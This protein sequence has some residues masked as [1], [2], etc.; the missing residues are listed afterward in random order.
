MHMDPRMI[1]SLLSAVRTVACVIAASLAAQVGAQ[2][3]KGESINVGA[4]IALTGGG[5]GVG[6]PERNGILLGQKVVNQRGGIN[7]R[8]LNVIIEDDGTSPDAA[9]TKV[10]QLV[11]SKKVAGILGTT[12]LGNTVAVGA[13]TAPL[14]LP[15]LAFSGIGPAV[16]NSRTCVFHMLPPQDLNARALLEYVTK[17]LKVKRVGVLHDS[18]YGNVVMASLKKVAAEYAV[19]FVQVEKFEIAAT[20]VTTQAA[21]V[22]AASP[23][24]VLV[25]ASTATAFRNAKQIKIEVPIVAAIGSSTNEIVK[26]MG[27]AA[28]GVVF[29]EFLVAEDPL[30]AQKEFV[31]EYFK[32]YGQNPKN[33]EAAGY[34]AVF[35]LA[36]ALKNAGPNATAEKVCAAIRAPFK[37]SMAQYDF[38]APDMTGLTLGSYNYSKVVGGKFTRLAFKA[39]KQSN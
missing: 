31:Q 6:I 12:M 17:E 11:Y 3:A 25:I 28:E 29:A 10:N 21:K 19:D 32:E 26:A 22:K 2:Q 34:D 15:Q 30:P 20:D 38:S 5:A 13:I 35:V 9:I 14:G 33:Y 27:D 16:E 37:G 36:T 18:G 7:G 4:V 1:S 23:Q 8:P 24:A 39:G